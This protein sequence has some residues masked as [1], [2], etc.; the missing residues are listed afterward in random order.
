VVGDR[1]YTGADD[2]N[3]YCI[4]AVTGTKI[5]ERYVD[6]ISYKF[7]EATSIQVRSSP[8]VIGDTLYV[9]AMNGNVYCLS[10]ADGQI[11]W[12]FPT[13][14]P[15]GG[16]PAYSGGIIYIASTDRN[17]Y[18]LNAINGDKIWNWTTTAG[19]ATQPAKTLF[20]FGT[21]TIANGVVYLGAGGRSLSPAGVNLVALNATTGA[22]IWNVLTDSDGNTNQIFAP[23]YFNGI[24]YGSEHMSISARN[25][26]D[27]SLIWIQ[28][29][30]FQVFS[31]VAYADDVTGPK[32]YVGC[33]S[34]SISCLNA[35]DGK[36]LSVYTTG[37]QVSSSPAIWGGKL[38]VGSG[39]G[40]VYCFYDSPTVS[41][42]ISA[43]SDKGAEMWSNET[44]VISGKLNPGIPSA[45][46]IV[47]LT[48]PDMTSINLTATTD[49]LGYFSFSYNPT[50]VGQWGWVAYY[51]GQEKPT[52]TYNAAYAQ[53]TAISV[54]AAPIAE[55]STQTVA[56]TE[57]STLVETATPTSVVTVTATPTTGTDNISVEYIYV[58]VAV[59]AIVVIAVAAF[60]YTRKR[61]K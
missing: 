40:N 39:D 41:V 22:L 34:Y 33:D 5:W 58:I 32:L 27:G 57:T 29:L 53:W 19:I 3:I 46:V 24:L 15:V 60:A 59:I 1:V 56:P 36:P 44:L 16:S 45:T 9:G 51:S 10:I 48:K 42:G 25:A 52:I 54:T 55:S 6:D 37:A 30:G 8:I 4:N 21:P 20:L 38:Y 43:S 31:S 18:A 2:G 49:N 50:E 23:T 26:T 14:G 17:L 11:K 12:T 61:K 28:W 35:T 13:G 7:F 47:S